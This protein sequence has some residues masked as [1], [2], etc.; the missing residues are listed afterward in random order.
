M[1]ATDSWRKGLMQQLHNA[2]PKTA[3]LRLGVFCDI[4]LGLYALSQMLPDEPARA[5]WAPLTG[6]PFA[7]ITA[8]EWSN[9]KQRMLARLRHLLPFYRSAVPWQ[10]ALHHY[11]EI[12]EQLRGYDVDA[13]LGHFQQRTPLIAARRW[14]IYEQAL[15]EPLPYQ[16]IP[17]RWAKPGSYRF[18][19]NRYRGSVAIPDDLPLPER[20]AAHTLRGV[21]QRPP[22]EVTLVELRETARWMDEQLRVGGRNAT[23]YERIERVGLNLFNQQRT[24]LIDSQSLTLDAMVHLVGMVG[25]GK[26][27]LMDIL[28]VC[29]ARRGQHVTL[30]VGDVMSALQHAELFDALGLR[31]A[32]ILGQSNRERHLKR[33]HRAISDVASSESLALEHVGFRWLSTACALDGLRDSQR[34]LG[35]VARPCVGLFPANDETDERP[36]ACPLYG[37][38]AFH[39]SQR[40]LVNSSIWI[41]T[42][43]SLIFTRVAPQINQEQVR[44]AELVIKRSDVIIIDEA[45]RVQIQLDSIFSPAQNLVSRAADAWLSRLDQLVTQQIS[46]EGRAQLSDDRVARWC[47]AHDTVQLAASRVYALLLQSAALQRTIERDYF[48]GWL[49]FERLARKLTGYSAE[50]TTRRS[51]YDA[52]M[53]VFE[54]CADDPLGDERDHPLAEFARRGVTITNAE[55]MRQ[56]LEEWIREHDSE[57][58]PAPS[59]T[60]ELAEQLEFGLA[61]AVLSNRLDVVIRDWRY[62][63]IPLQLEGAGSQLFHRPPDDYAPEVPAAPMGNVLAFQYIRNND[64]LEGPGDLRFFRCM[65]VGRWLLLNLHSR[66]AVDGHAGP[67][68]LLL[69]ATSWSGT[70]PGF[71]I[72]VPVTGVLRVPESEVEAVRESVF[73]YMPVLDKHAR[74]I[75]ISGRRGQERTDALRLMLAQ[76]A[77]RSSVGGMSTLERLRDQLPPDRQRLLLVVG[78][79]EEALLARTA[80]DQLRADWGGGVLHLVADDDQ[81]ESEW[82]RGNAGLQRGVVHRFAETNA[83]ILIAPLLAIERG[84][85]ILNRDQQAAIGA[86]LFL[87]RPHLRPDDIGFAIN[88]VNRWAIDQIRRDSVQGLSH[89]SVEEHALAFR[90]TAFRQWRHL[91]QLPMRYSTLPT[92]E[93]RAVTWGHL[94]TIW[95][96][97][98]RLV[99]GGVAARVYFCDAAFAPLAADTDRPGQ[100]TTSL[101]LS[102]ID[103]LR[104]YF[105]V[106]GTTQ[107]EERALA[108]MLYSPLYQALTTMRG[109][110]HDVR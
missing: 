110:S 24:E 56:E 59:R 49:I 40:D 85:N 90:S 98:G 84:H 106:T 89:P 14:Q 73:E 30:V 3:P 18:V 62:V 72:Q 45:D 58:E 34:P 78:S 25:A 29:L 9:D 101:L 54:A 71:D 99:R 107:P 53:E 100:R 7:E 26:S 39:Q 21:E 109:V 4:E 43:P 13:E 10:R 17:L 69:S 66:F 76:L 94:V 37:A 68:V 48:T 96:V 44:F 16:R 55:R 63:E 1:R 95:Q 33:L 70:A 2:W 97:I 86:A 47:Q 15:H 75:Q 23:W 60:S 108:H 51:E 35:L 105:T 91:I 82:Q 42:P 19:D 38:C 46:R 102:M 31:A 103:L 8:R 65:G 22:C 27:T 12:S 81:L 77:R 41:A 57:E 61:A 20:P 79:Y 83:W 50:N 28:A 64:D 6:Y 5:L 52:L 80:L 32:P 67:H 87:I 88:S 92:H 11:R 93:H 104:P 74:P 36:Q